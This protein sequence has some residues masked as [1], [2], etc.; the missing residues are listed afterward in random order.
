MAK[1][2]YKLM[3]K[4][5]QKYSDLIDSVSAGMAE[6]WWWTA[7]EIYS[8]GEFK[9]NLDDE[10]EIAGIRSSMWATPSIQITW[11][12]GSEEFMDCYEVSKPTLTPPEGFELGAMSKPCQIYVDEKRIKKL[13]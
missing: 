2:D 4:T 1:Y 13:N 12:D 7:E 10:P 9:V 11:K 3:K 5:V 8:D 6:D